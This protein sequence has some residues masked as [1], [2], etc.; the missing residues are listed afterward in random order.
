MRT[1]LRHKQLVRAAYNSYRWNQLYESHSPIRICLSALQSW[2]GPAREQSGSW[3]PPQRSSVELWVSACSFTTSLITS[4]G[5][6][7]VYVQPIRSAFLLGTGEPRSVICSKWYE[8]IVENSQGIHTLRWRKSDGK[9]AATTPLLACHGASSPLPM[10]DKWAGCLWRHRP[11]GRE[12]LIQF[13]S[14]SSTNRCL[15]LWCRYIK[16]MCNTNDRWR[17]ASSPSEKRLKHILC[18]VYSI[19]YH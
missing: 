18:C 10:T 11:K 15:H 1:N 9:V 13:P 2:C 8:S 17:T 12:C 4:A 7:V 3:I 6:S 5:C 19:H 14:R 16:L